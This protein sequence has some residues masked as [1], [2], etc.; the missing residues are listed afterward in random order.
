MG[1]TEDAATSEWQRRVE[2]TWFG[3]PVVF[4]AAGAAAGLHPGQPHGGRQESGDP[5]IVVTNDMDFDGPVFDRI[6]QRDLVLRITDTGHGRVYDGRDFHGG[7]TPFGRLLLGQDFIV[8]WGLDTV[9]VVQVLPDGVSQVYSNLAYQGP[10]LV[11]ALGGHYRVGVTDVEA[12][13]AEQ[14][15]WGSS[16]LRVGWPHVVRRGRGA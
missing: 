12:F 11:A 10:R 3:Y 6:Q 15:E 2:D 4:D 9:V 7:G 8:P 5:E 14:R 16:R 13:E 1:S